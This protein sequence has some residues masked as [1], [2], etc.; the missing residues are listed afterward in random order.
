MVILKI[1]YYLASTFMSVVKKNTN[2]IPWYESSVKKFFA[3]ITGFITVA[4]MGYGFACWQK[5]IEFR[6]KEIR[7]NQDCN[8]RLQLEMNKRKE[9]K[10]E[11][12]DKRVENLQIVVLNMQKSIKNGK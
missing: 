4:G 1:S 3:I 11:F 5:D 9:E 10:Q 12:E 8:E 7:L 2:K 6:M